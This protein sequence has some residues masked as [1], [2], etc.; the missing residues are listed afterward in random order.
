MV[1][2]KAGH[3]TRQNWAWYVLGKGGHGSRQRWAWQYRQ[4][5]AW[6]QTEVGIVPDRCGHG[7]RANVDKVPGKDGHGTRQRYLSVVG[8]GTVQ[9]W[10]W[11]LAKMVVITGKGGPCSCETWSWYQ[12]K[13]VMTMIL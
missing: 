10:A 11:Y 5:W 6:C 9:S 2:D 4:R 13:V 12:A 3:G 1:L 7:N 8:M